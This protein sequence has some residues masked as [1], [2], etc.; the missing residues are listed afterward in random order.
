MYNLDTGIPF[1][2]NKVGFDY[3]FN[4]ETRKYYPDVILADGTYLEIRGYS[5]PQFEAKLAAFPHKIVVLYQKD[6][7]VFLKHAR[8]KHGKGFTSVYEKPQM[9]SLK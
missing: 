4:G 7:Q 3:T 8:E 1:K 5:T 9:T 6:V 2:R